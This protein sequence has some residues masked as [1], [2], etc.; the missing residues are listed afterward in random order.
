VSES[1][2]Q[3]LF[4]YGALQ[5]AEMQLDTFGRLVEAEDDVLTG[6]SRAYAD[7]PGHRIDTASGPTLLPVL[8]HTGSAL[9]KVVGVVLALTPDELDAADEFQPSLYRRTKV[10]LESGRRA[11]LYVDIDARDGLL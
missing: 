5:G 3:L 9:D 7:T 11:W 2:D 1:A 6:Y 8:R 10:T 4:A